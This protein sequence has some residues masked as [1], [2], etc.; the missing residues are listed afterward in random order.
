MV[1]GNR[2][3]SPVDGVMGQIKN[4]AGQYYTVNPQAIN[5]PLDVFTA[6]RR[7][8]VILQANLSK[9]STAAPVPS[10]KTVDASSSAAQPQQV[11]SQTL[12]AAASPTTPVGIIAIGALL[13]GSIFWDKAPGAPLEKGEGLGGFKYG[14]ST[15]IVVFPD[16]AIRWD[17]DL[18]A[19]SKGEGVETLV[20]AG[21]RIGSVV[22]VGGR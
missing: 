13:V 21:E 17:G 18:V 10:D 22:R 12:K 6:N 19:N 5:E 8:I 7:D 2:F 11:P 4:L 1:F 3:H 20:R 16:G 9:S 14:G 15:V